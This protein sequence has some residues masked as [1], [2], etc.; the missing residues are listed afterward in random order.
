MLSTTQP[1]LIGNTR[2][3][4]TRV[5]HDE[6][7]VYV[8]CPTRGVLAHVALVSADAFGALQLLGVQ[9]QKV[10]GRTCAVSYRGQH[11]VDMRAWEKGG[12]VYV[13]LLIQNMPGTNETATV[14]LSLPAEAK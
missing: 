4:G 12:R 3:M 2:Y 13:D 7:R 10:A 8:N 5:D 14:R 6:H 1:L 9:V 11:A